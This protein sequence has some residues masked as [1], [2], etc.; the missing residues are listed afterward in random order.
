MSRKTIPV[1]D[2]VDAV[3]AML[4]KSIC[5]PEGRYGLMTLLERILHD[6]GNYWGFQFTDGDNGRTDDTRRRYYGGNA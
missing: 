6:T 2:V 3:N 5:G 4:E 1:A